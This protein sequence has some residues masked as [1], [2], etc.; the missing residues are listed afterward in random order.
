ML[1]G[2]EN[3]WYFSVSTLDML[4]LYNV[5][6]KKRSPKLCKWLPLLLSALYTIAALI[7]TV[8]A[9]FNG[10]NRLLLYSFFKSHWFISVWESFSL[11][12]LK[13]LHTAGHEVLLDYAKPRE[14]GGSDVTD[15]GQTCVRLAKANFS[16]SRKFPTFFEGGGGRDHFLPLK[17]LL[18]RKVSIFEINILFITAAGVTYLMLLCCL[19]VSMFRKSR[20]NRIFILTFTC[21]WRQILVF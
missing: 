5:N 16:K 3:Q 8:L 7:H 6:L 15:R 12:G 4:S 18:C 13:L 17:L 11:G 14:T 19:Y 20:K 10:I 1:K 21:F 9:K 2:K